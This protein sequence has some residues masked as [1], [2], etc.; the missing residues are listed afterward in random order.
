[1]TTVAVAAHQGQGRIATR[2]IEL[3]ALAPPIIAA[4]FVATFA[5]SLPLTDELVFVV[6]AARLQGATIEQL[7]AIV[8]TL[9]WSIAEHL[10]IVPVLLYSTLGPLF[11]FDSRVTIAATLALLGLLLFVLW[12]TRLVTGWALVAAS[13]VIFNP[14]QYMTFMWG[15]QVTF[16]L[17]T[18][19]AI[20][21]LA[22]AN[23]IE[24]GQPFLRRAVV[25]IGMVVLGVL[26]S[27]AAAF[28]FPAAAVMFG[29][30]RL[31]PRTK[32]A[33]V[34][35]FAAAFA[36]AGLIL[37][38]QNVQFFEMARLV[39]YLLAALGSALVGGGVGLFEFG[40]SIEV[41]LGAVLAILALVVFVVAVRQNRVDALALPAA[42]MTLSAL[43]I[44]AIGLSRP[45]LGNWHLQLAVPGIVG[46]VAA[47]SAVSIPS[48]ARSVA[49]AA[50][51]LP[52]A[53][54]YYNGFAT[55]GPDY[56]AYTAKVEAFTLAVAN[57]PSKADGTFSVT[58]EAVAYLKA[59][60]HPA[61]HSR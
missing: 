21:G 4:V 35:L 37:G 7:P 48:A 39:Y 6:N 17:S 15:Q 50:I 43:C 51:L 9:H 1:M 36:V 12:R 53:Y 5:R 18:V 20:T 41:I 27:S 56:A 31:R 46:L 61:F 40:P 3:V 8:P 14:S 22:V 11:T 29:L 23:G 47:I 13:V 44:A 10:I 2:V 60:G 34:A 16:T 26:S 42:L 28:A 33:L 58:P 24:D 52:A 57:D 59:I 45:Y 30:K 32:L 49:L 55:R 25:G 38:R 19:F 54:G